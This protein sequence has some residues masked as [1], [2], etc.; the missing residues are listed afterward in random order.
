MAHDR[1]LKRGDDGASVAVWQ[2]ALRG[3]GFADSDGVQLRADGVFG[4]KTEYATTQFQIAHGLLPTGRVDVQTLVK[5]RAMAMAVN[6]VL[7]VTPPVFIP[8][9][10]FTLAD[11]KTVDLVVVHTMEAPEKPTTAM[12]VAI[13]FAGADA[14]KA[15]AHYS[16]D[17][18]EVVQ[19]VR[20]SDV[21]WHA[22][23]A[24]R[25]GIGIEHAGFARQSPEE[26]A[27][28][29]STSMLALSAQLSARIA[30]RWSIPMVRL[31]VGE[32]RL[33]ARG[34]CGHVDCTQAFSAGKGHTDPGEFF[35]WEAYLEQV[36]VYWQRDDD[37]V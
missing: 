28:A 14:P 35:P 11:R 21:A 23:G 25:R 3:H 19:S 15:S 24:N 2:R 27:D 31:T 13:W 5:E 37:R 9:R 17:A 30:R 33:G 4:E 7:V 20:E 8:A 16:V 34:F 10:N 32:L 18:D 36:R 22:P 26:W 29:Y 6:P 12:D 1:V